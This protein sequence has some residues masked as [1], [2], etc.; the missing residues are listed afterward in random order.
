MGTKAICSFRYRNT[1]GHLNKFHNSVTTYC[2]ERRELGKE[3][4]LEFTYLF[5]DD[6]MRAYAIFSD[7]TFADERIEVP[8]TPSPGF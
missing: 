2:K 7:A 1:F 8:I 6:R 3:L 5:C 4:R